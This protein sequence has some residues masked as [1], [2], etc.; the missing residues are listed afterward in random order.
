MM[1]VERTG[2]GIGKAW[3]KIPNSATFYKLYDKSTLPV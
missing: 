1:S 3:I 2:F